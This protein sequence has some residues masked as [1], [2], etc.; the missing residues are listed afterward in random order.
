M[1]GRLSVTVCV[2]VVV[3]ALIF[4]LPRPM[5]QREGVGHSCGAPMVEYF[6]PGFSIPDAKWESVDG[7]VEYRIHFPLMFT[8]DHNSMSLRGDVRAY[9]TEF[10]E[11]FEA[12]S[13]IAG[14]NA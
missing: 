13:D 9:F 12:V 11:D 4:N 1:F 8:F 3:I 6:V 10:V 2:A 5:P 14:S 7:S